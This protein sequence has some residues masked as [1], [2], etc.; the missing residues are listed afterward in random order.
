MKCYYGDESQCIH[1]YG[2]SRLTLAAATRDTIDPEGWLDTGD[3]GYLDEEGF[4]FIKDRCEWGEA[5]LL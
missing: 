2:L 1:R 4:L 5:W 3:A